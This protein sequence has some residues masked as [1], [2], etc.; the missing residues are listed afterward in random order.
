M[1]TLEEYLTI[2]DRINYENGVFG[3]TKKEHKVSKIKITLTK[4]LLSTLY[5]SWSGGWENFHDFSIYPNIEGKDIILAWKNSSR[6][7]QVIVGDKI[8]LITKCGELI[9][10]KNVFEKKNINNFYD[11]F[12]DVWVNF[13][14]KEFM[15]NYYLDKIEYFVNEIRKHPNS[16]ETLKNTLQN[17]ILMY[18]HLCVP[19]VKDRTV[20]GVCFPSGAGIPRKPTSIF[21]K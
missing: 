3:G 6:M 10:H 15:E 8:T 14:H 16:E 18:E 19:D 20:S 13:F 4:Q 9:T 21:Y 1:K 11:D 2:I 12:F 5:D 17:V 7:I